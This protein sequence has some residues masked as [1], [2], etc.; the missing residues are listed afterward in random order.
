MNRNEIDLY[1]RDN[2]KN[3]KTK[4]LR[5][6][7]SKKWP[8]KNIKVDS[9]E[10]LS[11]LTLFIYENISQMER[12]SQEEFSNFCTVYLNSQ[13]TWRNSEFRRSL[14][15]I[16]KGKDVMRD[17]NNDNNN[18]SEKENYGQSFHSEIFNPILKLN[19][20]QEDSWENISMDAP[21]RIKT[22]VKELYNQGIRDHALMKV[23]AALMT[24][25]MLEFHEKSLFDLYFIEDMTTR[26]I[27]ER[28]KIPTT[29]V[30]HLLKDMKN[31]IRY[32]VQKMITP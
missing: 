30:H 29:A 22:Y 28:C 5:I 4:C 24:R 12:Y 26:Q 11:F 17:F 1:F 3:L 16:H 25:E 15:D 19:E 21:E 10:L 20:S 9:G 18:N 7:T 14:R 6:V 23:C 13:W 32:N 2:Y 31:K 27:A 8:S